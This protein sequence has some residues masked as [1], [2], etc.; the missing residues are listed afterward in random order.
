M[1]LLTPGWREYIGQS[2]LQLLSCNFFGTISGELCW[3]LFSDQDVEG[4]G[5]QYITWQAF[6]Q[7]INSVVTRPP[8]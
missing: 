8:D 6:F 7:L 5:A 1:L 3:S 4:L 2:R